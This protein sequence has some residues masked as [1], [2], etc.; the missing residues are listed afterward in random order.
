LT[1][2]QQNLSDLPGNGNTKPLYTAPH[3]AKSADQELLSSKM[4]HQYNLYCIY[5]NLY[6]VNQSPVFK[7]G[8]S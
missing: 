4:G 5:H 8:S 2:L 3:F 6:Y 1:K 7:A